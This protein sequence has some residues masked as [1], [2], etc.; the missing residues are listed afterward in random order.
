[1]L[2]WFRKA[3][4]DQGG[5]NCQSLINDASAEHING[6][7]EPLETTHRR[8]I[9]EGAT[10]EKRHAGRG[11]RASNARP[12]SVAPTRRATRLSHAFSMLAVR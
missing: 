6:Q 7:R 2:L 3:V 11:F 8:V 5:E 10:A 4:N 1:M 9:R 12:I